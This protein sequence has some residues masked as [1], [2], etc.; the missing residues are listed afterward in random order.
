MNKKTII[1]VIAVILVFF[2]LIKILS[3]ELC[4]P[5]KHSVVAEVVTSVVSS[6]QPLQKPVA[7]DPFSWEPILRKAL[8]LF[9]KA[10]AL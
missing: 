9:S 1:R 10:C 6:S 7:P 4:T 2:V 8:A 3:D 5:K